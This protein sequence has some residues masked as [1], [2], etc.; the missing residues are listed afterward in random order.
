MSPAE[1]LLPGAA[2][3]A[4]IPWPASEGAEEAELAFA[5][6][7]VLDTAVPASGRLHGIRLEGAVAAGGG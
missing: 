4:L 6:F 1:F 5:C 2:D 7:A 3:E